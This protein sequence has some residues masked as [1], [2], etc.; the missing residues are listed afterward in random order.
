LLGVFGYSV[1]ATSWILLFRPVVFATSSP[2]G[3][4]MAGRIGNRVTA[5]VGDGILGVGLLVI[6]LG[7]WQVSL[8][9]VVVGSILQGLGHG[10][11]RP[12]ISASLANSVDETD[13]GIAAASERMMFQ[14]GSA[15]GI[16]LLT[17]IYGGVDEP[18]TFA[19][20]FLVGALLAGLGAVALS[21]LRPGVY[22]RVDEI[23]PPEAA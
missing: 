2:L 10:L 5:F 20:T 23:E 15:L 18:G 19:Q 4:S 14:I 12:P 16:T 6:A 13:L 22:Q 1:A 3:G 7:A 9:I 11:V 17:V 8:V 21:F